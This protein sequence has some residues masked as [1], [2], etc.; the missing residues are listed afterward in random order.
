MLGKKSLLANHPNSTNFGFLQARPFDVR[1]ALSKHYLDFREHS[2]AKQSCWSRP[3]V[4]LG[5]IFGTVD[6]SNM[7]KTAKQT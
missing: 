6:G 1:Q 4:S 5:T 7:T 3:Q 2:I